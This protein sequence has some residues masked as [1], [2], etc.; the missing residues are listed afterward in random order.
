MS[1]QAM[2]AGKKVSG[3]S[4]KAEV[5]GQ[6]GSATL[7][8]NVNVKTGGKALGAP[9]AMEMSGAEL[10]IAPAL[11]DV[12][13]LKLQGKVESPEVR[14]GSLFGKELYGKASLEG[15]FRVGANADLKMRA[16]TDIDSNVLAEAE[17]FAGAEG[18]LRANLTLMTKDADGKSQEL[19]ALKLRTGYF[20]GI[21][22]NAGAGVLPR[23]PQ[24]LLGHGPTLRANLDTTPMTTAAVGS[25]LG[26][27]RS[28]MGSGSSASAQPPIDLEAQRPMPGAFPPG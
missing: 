27:V 23:T 16:Y 9:E 14:L 13:L 11:V 6:V 24:M 18:N 8:Y 26:S 19:G 21:K 17:G 4:G 3:D 7:G 5:K 12:S 28:W 20:A 22:G 15:D 1:A 25:A 10:E 2:E